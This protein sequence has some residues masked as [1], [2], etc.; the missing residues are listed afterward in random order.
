M[1]EE[2]FIQELSAF[3]FVCVSVLSGKDLIIMLSIRMGDP[4]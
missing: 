3:P 4:S 1:T 2:Q